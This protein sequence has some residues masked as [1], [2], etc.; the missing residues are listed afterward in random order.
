M[1]DIAAANVAY[2]LQK[3]STL[4]DSRKMNKVKLVFGDGAL[5]VGSGG[6]PLTKAKLGCPVNVDSVVVIDQGTSGYVFSYN[7]ATEKLTV[8][9]ADY[10]AIADGALAAFTGAIAAQTLYV[11]VIGY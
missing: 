3:A 7:Q 1:A 4:A 6:I 8:R 2:T 10:D 9:F 11:E 5:T